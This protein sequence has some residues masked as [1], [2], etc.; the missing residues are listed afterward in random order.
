MRSKPLIIF[1]L[2]VSL[3]AVGCQKKAPAPVAEVAAGNLKIGGTAPDFELETFGGESIRLSDKIDGEHFVCV[4]WHSPA[5]PCARNCATGIAKE[6][7]PDK[8][9]DLTIVGVMS[10]ANWDFD[11]MQEDL[12]QQIEDGIVTF[13][14][15]IDKDQSMMAKYGAERT[16][17]VW[18]LD[19]QGRIRYWGAPESTLEPTSSGYRFLLKEAVD[20]LRKGQKPP[21]QTFDPIGCK[22]MKSLG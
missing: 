17:T 11:Y 15:V 5:C 21:V 18:L 1:A 14:V 7:T 16:P 6:L 12:N 8:Y 3:L 9:P 4:I 2:I 19:K 22:I 20:A 10:D 13:P